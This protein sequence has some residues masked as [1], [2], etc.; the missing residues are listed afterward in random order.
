MYYCTG[1]IMSA[2]DL[3]L[4]EWSCRVRVVYRVLCSHHQ[5]VPKE[6][7]KL[8]ISRIELH[9]SEPRGIT[10]ICIFKS[11]FELIPRVEFMW[12][13]LSLHKPAAF[14]GAQERCNILCYE[15]SVTEVYRRS[16][17]YVNFPDTYGGAQ[18]HT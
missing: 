3:D 10:Q 11:L 2:L 15:T 14:D 13:S 8:T 7:Q 17:V 9:T 16:W 4:D 18:M 12:I 5:K 1:V 6:T